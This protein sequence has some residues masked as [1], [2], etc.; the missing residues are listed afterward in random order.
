MN[1][2]EF[3]KEIHENSRAHGW[4]DTPRPFDELCA[5]M[6]SELSEAL[7][8]ARAGRPMEWYSCPYDDD[9]CNKQCLEHCEAIGSL[10]KPEGIAVE[11]ADC[12]IRILDYLGYKGYPIDDDKMTLDEGAYKDLSYAF[13][14]ACMHIVDA[15][16]KNDVC[17]D[18]VYEVWSLEYALSI[19]LNWFEDNDLDF[20]A[21]ARRKHE[22]NKTRPYKHNK[23]F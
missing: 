14:K 16:E 15:H 8:E 18:E 10:P 2:N 22:Y 13:M 11:M 17:M 12:A 21:I 7:E 19:I 20:E 5:L 9:K 3:A 4:W 23:Q 6:I 1:L